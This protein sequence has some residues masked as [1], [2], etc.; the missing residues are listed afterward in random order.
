MKLRVMVD[1]KEI[2]V[3]VLGDLEVRP[4]EGKYELLARVVEVSAIFPT[5]EKLLILTRGPESF[6]K[7]V[8]EVLI[9]N[10]GVSSHDDFEEILKN[11]DGAR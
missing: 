7:F 1:H 8:R 11:A 9:I 10:D 3:E 2:Y 4:Y 6:V 5:Q